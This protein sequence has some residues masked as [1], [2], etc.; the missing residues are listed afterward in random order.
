MNNSF[1]EFLREKRLEKKL[2]QKELAKLLMVS[3]SAISKWEKDVA[4]PDITLLPKLSELLDVTEHELI[5][6]SVDKQ[7][8]E[9]KAQAKHWRALSMTWSLF[10]Y[11]AY[12]V[13]LIPCFICNLAINK[14]LSWFWIVLSA[15]LLAFTFTNLP[16]LIKRHRLIL[17]PLS[18]YLA[19]S[20]LLGVCAIYTKGNWFWVAVLSILF[21]L[22]I[23]F[24][25]IYVSKYN[26]FA[27]VRKYN[28]F[29]SIGIDFLAL[30]IL[31]G[32]IDLY[33]VGNGYATNHWFF[34][35]ALPIV[36][37]IYLTISV[38]MSVRFLKINRLLRTSIVLT[39]IN[40]VL[41]IIP[42]LI[43]VDNQ[44]VQAELDSLNVFKSDF[45]NWQVDMPLSR[46]ISCI[47]FLTLLGI[48]AIFL[49]FG[50]IKCYK[51]RDQEK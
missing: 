13:A 21:G 7:S 23:I 11:V 37:T 51:N 18:M 17:I 42:L 44:E 24:T 10:F 50:L 34:S 12:V 30:I 31:L 20:L 43:K 5:T 3:E 15:L 4:H 33:S 22:I 16:K 6:A 38:I 26:V 14:T 41:F 9:E 8:R 32:V 29:V 48:S 2:T 45:T 47:I 25:P 28:D 40:I 39:I 19:L 36:V 35:V 27:R 1:G 49:M 46:N